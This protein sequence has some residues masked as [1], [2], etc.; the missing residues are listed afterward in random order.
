MNSWNA[1]AAVR[2]GVPVLAP[3]HVWLA[4]AGP[5][6]PGLLTLDAL[7][8]LCQADVIVH[9][10]LVD[11]RV[12]A[13]AGSQARLEFAGKRGGR[14]SP[15]QADISQRLVELARDGKRVLRL[16]GGDPFIFGRGGEEALTLAAAGVPFRI[17]PGVTAGL[18]ALA[19]ALIPVTLRGVNRAVVFAAGYGADG[20]GGPD[21]AALARTGAP[22][23][24]YMAMRNLAAIAEALM[25]G[26][27]APATPAA[28]IVS[29]TTPEERI[30]VS[31]LERVA[32]DAREQGFEP[33]S[34]VAIG[35]IVAV[36]EQL[37]RAVATGVAR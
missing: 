13:L 12:L 27:L 20:A 22:I 14:P 34:I 21:W 11:K 26:G 5:G 30:L 15:T 23:V 28:V 7:A 29:A 1:I 16:K 18:A 9:D 19:A 33:P 4:G 2:G 35:D 17:I 10:A 3:G 31:T 8:G 32:A 6:D 25:R 37:I 24:L 36:R